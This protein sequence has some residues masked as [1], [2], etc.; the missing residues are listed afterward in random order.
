MGA[1]EIT[2]QLVRHINTNMIFVAE[3]FF[4]VLFSPACVRIFL[5]GD[6]RIVLKLCW[7]QALFYGL[8]L[9]AAVALTRSLNITSAS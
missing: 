5:S 4:I 8:V 6:M 3:M 9:R 2:N 7:N 1:S